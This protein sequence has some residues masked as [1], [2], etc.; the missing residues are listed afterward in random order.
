MS[1]SVKV[2]TH[3]IKFVSMYQVLFSVIV[4]MHFFFQLIT[5]LAHV[6]QLCRNFYKFIL[7]IF[8]IVTA[9]EVCIMGEADCE[10]LCS[11]NRSSG[12]ETCSCNQG[13]RLDSNERNCSGMIV[14]HLYLFV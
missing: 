3:A 1:M 2:A 11:R 8:K 7:V 13:Y 4:L 12:V 6:C 5:S 9:E 10:Q 14:Y